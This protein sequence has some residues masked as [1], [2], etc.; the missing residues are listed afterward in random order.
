MSDQSHQWVAILALPAGWDSMSSPFSD[1]M[2]L[3]GTGL[4]YLNKLMENTWRT[5]IFESN[6]FVIHKVLP[7]FTKI[8]SHECLEPHCMYV[9]MVDDYS[10]AY[11]YYYYYYD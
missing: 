4:K 3:F 10:L 2:E 9:C 6:I 1:D 8:L 5:K 11:Y 7:K